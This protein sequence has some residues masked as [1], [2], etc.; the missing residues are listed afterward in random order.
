MLKI[1]KDYFPNDDQLTMKTAVPQNKFL[2]LVNLVLTST[3]HTFNSQFYQQTDGVVKKRPA[4]STKAEVY[5]QTCEQTA[6]PT[7]L[8]PSKVWEQFAN[9]IHSVLKHM[10][11]E[12]LFYHINS[13]HQ[14]IEVTMEEKVYNRELVFL[15]TLLKHN[16]KISILVYK[17]PKHTDKYQHYHSHC[18]TSYKEKVVCFIEHIP[19]SPIRMT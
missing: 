10:Q 18:Q 13:L 7:A 16:G 14:N 3:W 4:S 17:K 8:H 19:L 9:D 12:N 6:I 5:I 15:D 1:I 11:L 2:D